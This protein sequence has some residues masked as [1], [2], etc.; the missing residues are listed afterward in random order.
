MLS[1]LDWAF[2]AFE[3]DLHRRK[4]DK[5]ISAKTYGK[6]VLV[7][8]HHVP[9]GFL[10]TVRQVLSGAS[11]GV[12]D[13][14]RELLFI[15]VTDFHVLVVD[16]IAVYEQKIDVEIIGQR[17]GAAAENPRASG[18]ACVESAPPVRSFK[19][20]F[21]TFVGAGSPCRFRSPETKVVRYSR[22]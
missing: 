11:V 7:L 14:L 13:S 4:I 10:Q 19:P 3:L 2:R 22:R 6:D 8:Q 16:I 12:I 17:R 5:S 21:P 15:L 9:E 18:A 1:H 20:S